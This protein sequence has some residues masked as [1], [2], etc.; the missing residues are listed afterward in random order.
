MDEI[1]KVKAENENLDKLIKEE[2]KRM[3][4]NMV[5]TNFTSNWSVV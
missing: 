1:K 2:K 3:E 4:E 5:K